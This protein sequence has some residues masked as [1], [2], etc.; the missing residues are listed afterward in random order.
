MVAKRKAQNILAVAWSKRQRL[1]QTR[2]H[3]DRESTFE[4]LQQAF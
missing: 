2:N 1:A 3:G 4:D